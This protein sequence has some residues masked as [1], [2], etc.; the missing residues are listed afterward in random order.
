[1]HRPDYD[2][3]VIGAGMTGLSASKRLAERGAR[4]ADI[5]G[6]LFGGLVTN[7]NELEGEHE[8]SGADLAST[9]M[10]QTGELG[11]DTLSE[12]VTGIHSGDYGVTVATDASILRG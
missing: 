2:V 1:M 5:E 12:T 8:G 10:M 3:I 11:C 6:G 7:V 9:L 4:V